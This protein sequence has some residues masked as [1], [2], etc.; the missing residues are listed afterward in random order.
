M[1]SESAAAWRVN[2]ASVRVPDERL[3]WQRIHRRLDA[4]PVKPGWSDGWSGVALWRGVTVAAAAAVIALGVFMRPRAG[5]PNAIS[6]AAVAM[7]DT[8]EVGDDAASAMVF[9]DE[10][11]GWLVVWA[12]SAA[13]GG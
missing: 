10:K 11:S 7:T 12:T 8:A 9:V 5:E 2:T 13:D 3:E 6:A 1:W 4:D